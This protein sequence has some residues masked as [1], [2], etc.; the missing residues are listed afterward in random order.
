[1]EH[2]KPQLGLALASLTNITLAQE[3]I[4]GQTF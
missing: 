4:M 3:N 1:V 2:C